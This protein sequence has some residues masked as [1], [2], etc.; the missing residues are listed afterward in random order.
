MKNQRLFKWW[1]ASLLI[2]LSVIAVSIRWLDV[3][4][5]RFFFVGSSRVAALG[6][7]LGSSKMVTGDATLLLALAVIR[8]VRGSLPDYAKAVF[9]ACCASLSAFAANDYILKQIFGRY[10][11]YAFPGNPAMQAFNLFHGD[12][13]C[14][15]P[16]GH[17]VISTTFAAVLV[18]VY[19]RTWPIFAGL[20]GVGALALL[21]GDWHFLSDII[22][23]AFV[24]VTAGLMAGD[25]W[26]QRVRRYAFGGFP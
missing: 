26:A 25:L 10:G 24:G 3:P 4:I 18:R 12:Q 19:P 7:A 1:C 16:S 6:Q 13:Y 21:V 15:F 23:G 20:L 5:A 14:V 8:M 9:I 22:A 2:T 11:P 17:M